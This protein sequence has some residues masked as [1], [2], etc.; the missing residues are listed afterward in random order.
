MV[1]PQYFHWPPSE[2]I[3]GDKAAADP[4]SL[5]EDTVM[6]ARLPVAGGIDELFC[7]VRFRLGGKS[8]LPPEYSSAGSAER[9]QISDRIETHVI[10]RPPAGRYDTVL[11]PSLLLLYHFLRL[12]QDTVRPV[13]RP[14]GKN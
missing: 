9:V 10:T 6:K 13:R 1:S 2:I 8:V 4:V 12:M 14:I 11:S 3:P 5:P 7:A